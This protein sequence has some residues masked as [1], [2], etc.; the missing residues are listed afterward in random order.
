MST[1]AQKEV[2][3]QIA[4]LQRIEAKTESGA[5]PLT[6]RQK[7]LD[8]TKMEKKDPE[9]AYRYISTADPEKLEARL[10]DFAPVPESEA[11]AAGVKA[12]VGRMMLVRQPMATHQANVVAQKR[13]NKD[14]LEQHK[15]EMERVVD[16][17]ARELRDKHGI[18][19][20]TKRLFVNE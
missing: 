18:A 7:M 9:R 6:P 13:R 11:A 8:A 16:A 15:T 5:M 2:E 1:P 3:K 10:Q 12:K 17:V 19:V 4:D 14:R 20:D